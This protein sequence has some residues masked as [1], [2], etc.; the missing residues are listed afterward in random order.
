MEVAVRFSTLLFVSCCV[1]AGAGVSADND[2]LDCSHRSLGDA[3]KNAGANDTIRFTGVCTGPIVIRRNGLTLKGVGTAVI[4]GAGSDAVTV[5]GA[6]AP[7]STTSRSE[8]VAASSP[9]TAPISR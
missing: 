3:V 2:V 1:L 9:P 4:D 7:R 6:A 8:R 5:A